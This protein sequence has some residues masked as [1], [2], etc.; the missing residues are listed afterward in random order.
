MKTSLWT[1]AVIFALAL[2]L[3]SGCE[4]EDQASSL[5]VIR[6]M[7][8]EGG[9]YGIVSDAG[10]HF[11]PENLSAEF[12]KDGLRIS[13]RGVITDKPTVQQWGRTITL[14]KIERIQ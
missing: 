8:I 11:L 12:Q 7:S 4:K 2:P 9:F 3:L 13:F 5:G 14:T 6:Y 10:D 1:V